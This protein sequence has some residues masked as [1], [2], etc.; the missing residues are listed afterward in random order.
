MRHCVRPLAISDVDRN[1]R[2]AFIQPR[3]GGATEAARS[4]GHDGNATCE[5]LEVV[6]ERHGKNVAEVAA[7][8][9]YNAPRPLISRYLFTTAAVIACG[10]TSSTVTPAR[11]IRSSTA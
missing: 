2:A 7:V 8:S 1:R 3:G 10:D 6:G 9:D 5:V 11:R 4:A